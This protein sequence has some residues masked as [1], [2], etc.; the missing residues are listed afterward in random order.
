[1][2]DEPYN[3]V[4]QMWNEVKPTIMKG[5]CGQIKGGECTF[6][7]DIFSSCPFRVDARTGFIF[8]TQLNI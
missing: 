7:Q 5:T 2:S 6:F 4:T 3:F 1:M 8:N